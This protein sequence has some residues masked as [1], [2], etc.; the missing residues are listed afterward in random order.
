MFYGKKKHLLKM[1]KGLMLCNQ[2]FVSAQIKT[3]TKTM[4][5]PLKIRK[6]KTL[7]RGFEAMK[8]VNL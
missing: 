5:N 4:S 2:V 7:S 6:N 8:A 1:P 3:K